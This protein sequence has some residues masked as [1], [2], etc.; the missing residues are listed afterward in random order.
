[1]AIY[2]LFDLL[3]LT[4]SLINEGHSFADIYVCPSDD[5]FPESLHF[6]AV[7]DEF[8]S[9]E[10]VSISSCPETDILDGVSLNPNTPLFT[11]TVEEVFLLQSTLNRALAY[12]KECLKEPGISH[13]DIDAIKSTD[14]KTRNLLVKVEKI[15]KKLC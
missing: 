1:M 10:P 6:E 2:N 7:I 15:L 3:S 8:E 12:D 13:Q 9:L 5:E 11:L 14:A 4:F